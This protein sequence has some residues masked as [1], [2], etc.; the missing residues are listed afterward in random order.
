MPRLLKKRGHKVGLPPGTLLPSQ[1][2]ELPGRCRLIKYDQAGFSEKPLSQDETVSWEGT[3]ERGTTWIQTVGLDPRRLSGLGEPFGLHPLVLEDI[4]TTDQR[5]KMEDLGDS[6][7]LTA[8]I[9]SLAQEPGKSVLQAEQLS[10]VLGSNYLLSFQER[11]SPLFE[12]I[13][14]RLRSGK[15]KGR[16][17]GSDFLAYLLLDIL[18]DHYFPILENLGDRIEEL[19]LKLAQNPSS[20]D[21]RSIEEMKREAF[22]LRKAVWPLRDVVASLERDEGHIITAG[23]RPYL[24]DLYD[25]IIQIIDA[26]E[27]CRDLLSG[28]VDLYMSSISNRLNQVMKVLTIISTLFIPLT[29]LVGVYG[30]NFRYM[31]ELEWKYSYPILWVVMGATVIFMIRF[32]KKK[33]WF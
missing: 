23:L 17:M 11:E 3:E 21:L 8:K 10:L 14:E 31:P 15:G 1:Q 24:R 4:Q 9:L 2:S 16:Q 28:M 5:T 13:R 12:P 30:M 19:E 32:F 22:Y 26:T 33:R 6:L 25:H 18:V 27:M 7:F 20:S 29:F